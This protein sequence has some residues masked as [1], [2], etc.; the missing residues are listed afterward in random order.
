MPSHFDDPR[1]AAN[2]TKLLAEGGT[3]AHILGN[4]GADALAGAGAPRYPVPELSAFLA[5]QR[6]RPTMTA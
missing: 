6:R 2:R 4:N 5:R 1:N 3:E